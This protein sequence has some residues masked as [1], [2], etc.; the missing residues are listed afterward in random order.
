MLKKN[1][2]KFLSFLIIIFPI[3]L[4]T[5]PL[6]AEVIL[7]VVSILIN[8]QIIQNKKFSYYKFQF[9]Y[10][11]L[12]FWLYL[13]TNS[14]FAESPLWSLKTSIFYFRYY[15]FLISIVY[16]IEEK[17]LS[18]KI[19]LYSL[20]LTFC[21][22]IFDLFI[23]YYFGQNLL[24]LSSSDNRYS[25][26]F[27]KELIL[28][29]FL[30]KLFP[31]LSALFFIKKNNSIKLFYLILVNPIIFTA[32]ILTGERT[33]SILVMLFI[34]CTSFIIIEKY[35]Y[36]I[37]YLFVI[38]VLFLSMLQFNPSIKTR[39][40]NDT[41]N[42]LLESKYDQYFKSDNLQIESNNNQIYIFSKLHHGHILSA[43]KLF[44]EKPIFGNGVNSF[45]NK[46]IK[47]EH[48]YACNTHPHNIPIQIL[49]EIGIVGFIFYI[50]IIVFFISNLLNKNNSI[51]V[52][53]L[54]LGLIL[55]LFPLAPSG[56]FFNN[57]MNMIFYFLIGYYFTF[58]RYNSF[59]N[60]K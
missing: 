46:C 15:I 57:W 14:I 34:L 2:N 8:Y 5:G 22:L 47:F 41:L 40:I 55:Y 26:L 53:I 36:R 18:L 9:S 19:V 12:I 56:N 23:Q 17:F 32:I 27:G 39:F 24:G 38:P 58:M 48:E 1:Y 7:A 3:S 20:L 44:L 4:V 59:I 35:R 51:S 21:F 6:I 60:D 30:G 42:Y 52:K 43:Y 28:G 11:F 33:A 10:F 25:G 13:I 49:S 45:R 54:S 16:L 31:L 50:T 37:I 29:S